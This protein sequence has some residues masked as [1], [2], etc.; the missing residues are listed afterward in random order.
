L[1]DGATNIFEVSQKELLK[2]YWLLN[3]ILG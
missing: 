3:S 2:S 1:L